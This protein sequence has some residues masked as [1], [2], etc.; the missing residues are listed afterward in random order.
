MISIENTDW[1]RAVVADPGAARGEDLHTA[2]Q[3]LEATAGQLEDD[4]RADIKQT[5]KTSLFTRLRSDVRLRR[6]AAQEL[7]R[8]IRSTLSEVRTGVAGVGVQVEWTVRE[9][10]DAQRMVELI[11]QRLRRGLRADV[12]RAASA[13]GRKS[14][15]AWATASPH[16]DYRLARLGNLP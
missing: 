7:V 6:E 14:R 10:E 11:S 9:D 5:L 15:R 2:V 4:L 1:R 13:N 12:R 8:K 3:A 16:L